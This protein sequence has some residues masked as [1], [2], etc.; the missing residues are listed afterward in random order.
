MRTKK[1][2]PQLACLFVLLS[3]LSLF[4]SSDL[5]QAQGS[6]DEAL[7]RASIEHPV[8]DEVLYFL[9]PDRFSDG[10]PE[11]NWGGDSQRGETEADVLRHGYLPTDKGYYHGGD[12]KG[13]LNKL[14]Y[15]EQMGV[16]AIWVGPIFRNKPVQVDSSNLY[17]HSSGYHGY[18]ILD[19]ENVDPHLGTNQDFKDLISAAHS[20]GIKIFMDIITNHTADVIQYQENQFTYRNKTDAPYTDT[21]DQP[22]DDAA[23]AYYGQTAYNFPAMDLTGFPYTPVISSTEL[24][25]KNPAWLN[26][27]LFYHNRGNSTFQ[28]ESSLYGDFSG[29]DDLFTEKK[30]VV[31]GMVNIYKY[32]IEEFGPDGFRIDTTKHANMEFWQVFGPDILTAAEAEQIDH[33]FAFGEVY[34]QQYGPSFLSEFSTRGKLQ[35][36]IDFAFQMAARD[37]ASHSLATDGLKTFFE[38]DD[39]YT[40]ADSNAYAVPTFLGNHDMG[41]IG[42][43]LKQ[44]NPGASD[45]ELLARSKLAHALMFFA[46]GEPVIYYGDE[47][48]FTGDGGDKDAR[49]DMFPSQVASYNDNDLIGTSATTADDNFDPSHPLY[50]ALAEYSRIYQ[51]HQALRRGAQIHRYSTDGPGLYVFSRIDR[52]EKVEYVV[53][54]N[55][56]EIEA[57]G[58][59]SV[60]TFY[61]SKTQFALVYDSRTE[62]AGILYFPLILK[63]GVP[64]I[65]WA[66]VAPTA[67]AESSLDIPAQPTH[68]AGAAPTAPAKTSPDISVQYTDDNGRLSLTVPPLSFV[69]YKAVP[70][71]P[72]SSAAPGITLS[73]LTNGQAVTLSVKNLDGH[74]ITDRIEVKAELDQPI[75]AEVT[76]AVKVGTATEYTVIGT[77][78]APPYRVFYHANG[79]PDGTTLQFKAIVN[80]LSGHLRSTT[81]T[82]IAPHIETT[83]PTASLYDYAVIHYNRP[84]GDYGDHTI[85]GDYWGLHLWG[86]AITTTVDWGSP[87]PFLGQD[88]YGRF[89]WVRLADDSKALNFIVHKGD[90]KDTP[91]DRGFTPRQS[92]EIWLKQGDATIYT[93]RAEAQGYVNVHYHRTAADYTGWGLHLWQGANSFTAWGN[94]L[95]PGGFDDYGAVFTITTAAYPALDLTQPLSFII[96]NGDTKDLDPDRSFNPAETAAIWLKQADIT[97]YASRGA[98]ENY[99]ILHYH[100]DAGDYGDSGSSNYEDYWGMHTWGGAADPGWTT[101]RKPE[102]QDVFG[103]YFKVPLDAGAGQVSYILHR[104]N[105]KDPGPDQTLSL[106]KYGY[107]VWQLQGAN[108]DKPYLLPI[109]KVLG[110]GDLGTSKAHWLTQNI[111]AWNPKHAADNS[112]ALHYNPNGGM[113]LQSGVITSEHAITLTYAGELSADLKAKYPHLA[114]FKAFTIAPADLAQVPDIL[115]GQMAVSLKNSGIVMDATGVQIPGVLDD[116]YTYTGQLGPIYSGEDITLRLWAPTAQSVTLHLF[117]DSTTA[118]STTIAMTPG[119][120]G[121][122][123]T[124]LASADWNRK[125]YLYGVQVYAPSTGQVEYNLVTDPYSL[126]LSTNSRRSL[127]VNLDDADLKPAGWDSLTK[128]ALDNPE[129]I[130]LYELHLRDFSINDT[131]LTPATYRGTFKA[132]TATGSN[133]MTHLHNLADAGLTHVHLLPVFDFAT[134]E[135]NAASRTE[136]TIPAASA[137][138]DQ[139]QAAVAAVADLD[140]YNWGYDPYHY[141]VPEGSYSTNPD[142]VTRILEFR[143]MVKALDDIELRLVMDVVYNHTTASG[144]NSRSVLDK[145]VPGYYHRLD[146]DGKVTT[147]TCCQNTATEHAMMEK[148]MI[149]SLVT[150]AKA[151]KVDGFRFDLMGHHMKANMLKV[152]DTLQALTL[153]VD[154]VDGSKI[155][156]YGEGWD[157]GEVAGGQR[158]VNATQLNMAGT[159]IGTFND[160]IRD[161]VRGGSPFDSGTSLFSNQ[162]F[163]NGVAYDPNA[164]ALALV[165]AG[166]RTAELL[167]STDQIMV[168]LAGNLADYSLVDRTGVVTT[169]AY[170]DYNGSPTGYTQDPQEHIAYISAHD[171]QTLFDIN[172][173]KIP[174]TTLVADRVR[175]QNMGISIA[176]LSQ[177]VPFFDA[178]ADMLRSKSLDQD[179]Y[180]SGDWFN[181][182]DFTYNSN[183][184]G[185]GLPP[186][187]ANQANWD[188]MRPLLTNA[189][190]Y[191]TQVNI[192]SS[193]NHL[194]EMLQIRKSSPLF[195][196]ATEQD[197]KDRVK[198][199]NT[200]PSQLPGLIVMDISDEVGTDLDPTYERIVVFFN[201]NDEAQTFI[202]GA[203]ALTGIWDLHPIQAAS[204]DPVVRTATANGGGSFTIPA[205]TTAV[206]VR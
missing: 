196:L 33:F 25:A 13:L 125:Y 191:P 199:Y 52:D 66:G 76:F 63:R 53:A 32:W 197:I 60:P 49:E 87:A 105:T 200:G 77:D 90:N 15:L 133:G 206:F 92:P 81:V 29:L 151:Y 139:Q 45:A 131:S 162:G 144:Q 95:L 167:L 19:Y 104:G 166:S 192:L 54:F 184:W 149:D 44:D 158:G 134:V 195:R 42:Y 107:E 178:G 91:N 68:E 203:V 74:S 121:T 9:V 124:T 188:L 10:D 88:D 5:I 73:N 198:F 26:D 39:Y 86:E 141:T 112:Y 27:P 97:N 11:N 22:F 94:P 145:V 164:T 98:A 172:Q 136:P 147:S 156:L 103:I 1:F 20:R 179:S 84:A 69:I 31:E 24:T 113:L 170:V 130:V 12:L 163:I 102:G 58:P 152:R 41:R 140:G 146:L 180:N 177:G 182:L 171:N 117:N 122:W 137:D 7:V 168:G 174:T 160:R 106:T 50:Q 127:L 37:F 14:D 109:L 48:G 65:H 67:A 187:G 116:L 30:E 150:W 189:N 138:S 80:D 16:T 186:A 148:L 115:K 135:E 119:L 55:N 154:G 78:N 6:E 190:I 85:P 173:Y 2:S 155:Y 153:A 51:N 161:A 176:A 36:T 157:F 71:I 129:D 56:S 40:D 110:G 101:P 194:Q 120:S 159:G 93:T 100:R 201:A 61:S 165:P 128:P 142:G 96:H 193:V 21:A 17:G 62:G 4:Q 70:P 114:A 126:G 175:V 143:E 64:P 83:G 205:R 183:N 72:A 185:V 59:I 111:I 43:F 38:K 57:T 28:G 99:A 89:A 3:L 47:Q 46:R 82:G 123:S 108:I 118:I 202:S 35:S 23:Y 132:F 181:K 75:F 204:S 8:Q 79:L 34:D 18:W 169:G